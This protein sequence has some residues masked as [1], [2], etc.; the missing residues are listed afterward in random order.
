M[1]AKT[2]TFLGVFIGGILFW[3]GFNWTM[4]LTDT[5]SFCISCHEMEVNVYREYKQSRHYAN[6]SGV[7][8]TCPDCHVPTDWIHKVIRKVGATNE[9]YHKLLGTVDTPEKFN[10]RRTVLADV[11]WANMRETDSREC[12]NCHEL[13]FM[14]LES[15]SAAARTMHRLSVEWSKTCIDCHQGIVHTLPAGFDN[16]KELDDQHERMEKENVEC[17]LCH[18]GMATAPTN[19]GWKD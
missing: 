2:L 9:L 4:E 6:D 14:D 5:E 16:E 8:A 17:V 15:Q 7:R 1:A 10:A 12:R 18:E 11:V 19:D 3:G 13:G